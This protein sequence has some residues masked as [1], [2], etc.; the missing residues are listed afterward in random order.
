[1][2]ADPSRWDDVQLPG[3]HE[4]PRLGG[5]ASAWDLWGEDAPFGCLNLLTPSRVRQAGR[6]VQRGAMFSLNLPMTW[7]DPPL[8]GRP[9]M[10]HELGPVRIASRDETISGWNT[11]ASTQWDGFR[12]VQRPGYGHFGRLP[13]AAQGIHPWAARGIAGRAVL[14]D[15]SG[16][17]QA[18]GRPL[19]PGQPDPITPD[20][21]RDCLSASGTE[22]RQGDILLVRTGWLAWYG[23][24]DQARRAAL[25][26]RQVLRSAGLEPSEDMAEFLWDL[27][28]AAVAA[29]NPALEVWPIGAVYDPAFVA[30]V[31]A[32]PAREHEIQLHVRILSML[33]IPIGEL[34]HLDALARD[35]AADG[36]Y[37]CFLT[38]APINLPGAVASPPN[39][40]AFK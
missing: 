33:G 1:M 35:C 17:R 26:D 31:R 10:R 12:H 2:E 3:Y 30:A 21:L 5:V 34:F 11:Q 38:S 8:F 9:A 13:E 22:V 32:D 28:V 39:A 20:D 37:E 14:A 7:P 4:L 15:V 6:L 25:A 24:Q 40:L 18:A 36:R 29:D 16:W 27:H 19:D 23:Q